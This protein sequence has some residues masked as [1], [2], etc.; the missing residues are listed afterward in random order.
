MNFHDHSA[1]QGCFRLSQWLPGFLNALNNSRQAN[2]IAALV[3]FLWG[4][5]VWCTSM[6]RRPEMHFNANY[7][8]INYGEQLY[9]ADRLSKGEILYRDVASQYGF[10]ASYLYAYYTIAVGNTIVA[11]RI[12]HMLWFSFSG[13]MVYWLLRK[14]VRIELAFAF[15]LIVVTPVLV[16]PGWIITE[17]E[18]VPV[19]AVCFLALMLAWVPPDC[20]T[21]KHCVTLGLI[22]GLWQ[23]VKFGGAVYAGMAIVGVDLLCL[24]THKTTS[25]TW[26]EWLTSLGV[27]VAS[28]WII[29]LCWIALAFSLLPWNI[30]VDTLWPAYML[31]DYRLM[32]EAGLAR[33]PPLWWISIKELLSWGGYLYGCL[34]LGLLFAVS[35]IVRSFKNPV[36]TDHFNGSSNRLLIGWFFYLLASVSYLA[37]V[38]LFFQYSWT[39]APAAAGFLSR[40]NRRLQIAGL[41]LLSFPFVHMMKHVFYDDLVSRKT[42]QLRPYSLPSSEVIYVNDDVQETLNAFKVLSEW[43][44]GNPDQ[45]FTLAMLGGFCGGGYH[46]YY[47]PNYR[48]RNPMFFRV[49]TR[50]YDLDEFEQ[51][52]ERVSALIVPVRGTWRQSLGC[53]NNIFLPHQIDWLANDFEV[54][55]VFSCSRFY[56][57]LRKKRLA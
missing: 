23:A 8:L 33:V 46:Y 14:T 5:A 49:S 57:A 41:L 31:S 9:R 21:W 54:S 36:Q 30:A 53:L 22:L 15:T 28:F 40:I 6:V 29:Q 7:I 38:G 12:W 19:E 55:R 2:A 34:G 51:K 4:I 42:S 11:N 1:G 18:N 43:Q 45:S 16:K 10:V 32:R 48:M 26:K 25:N 20:R 24:I 3:L 27:I 50:L 52:Y 13:V 56:I 35:L 39:I 47:N 37:H 44:R 17:A